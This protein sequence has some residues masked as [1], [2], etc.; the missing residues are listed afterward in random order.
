MKSSLVD[1]DF[2][3]CKNKPYTLPEK[4]SEHRR[5]AATFLISS[6]SEQSGPVFSSFSFPPSRR[7]GL[8]QRQLYISNSQRRK[9]QRRKN[10]TERE[11]GS[12]E[13]KK[14]GE[15]RKKWRDR[16]MD[17]VTENGEVK[18]GG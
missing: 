16:W 10:G 11:R 14:N 1:A 9:R 7:R 6:S 13:G 18:E 12:M 15:K 8:I 4:R 17:V 3:A 5:H 2:T